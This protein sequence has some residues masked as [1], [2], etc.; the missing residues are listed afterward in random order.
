MR[1]FGRGEASKPTMITYKVQKTRNPKNLEVDYF[2][3]VA[4]KTGDYDFNDFC[5]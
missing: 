2:H 1:A 4:V 5:L 3:G